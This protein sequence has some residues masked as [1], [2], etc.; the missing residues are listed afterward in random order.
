M[1]EPKCCI[2]ECEGLDEDSGFICP[3]CLK[4]YESGELGS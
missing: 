4:K 2:C 3:E 1:S